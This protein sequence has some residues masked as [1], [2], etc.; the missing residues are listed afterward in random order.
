MPWC[1]QHRDPQDLLLYEIRC[2]R[3]EVGSGSDNRKEAS[4]PMSKL[5]GVFLTG[6][7][8]FDAG[9]SRAAPAA[10]PLLGVNVVGV[11]QASQKDRD[12]LIAQLQQYGVKTVRTALGGRD[13]QYT[14]F[15]ISAYQHGISAIVLTDPFAG[16]TQKHA[17]AADAAAGR[18]WGLPALSDA[19][20]EG[21][22]KVFSAQLAALEAAGVK[23][24]A[25]EFGNE[26]NTPRFNADFRPDQK[27]NRLLGVADLNNPKDVEGSTVAAGY[28]AYLK[29]LATLKALRDHSKVNS[30]TP[31]LS[32]MSAVG[33]KGYARPPGTTIPDAV[34]IAESIEF[35][36]QN[37]L[38][39]LVDGY[40][41]HAYQS[42]DPKLSA[43][44]RAALL[45]QTGVTTACTPAK[46]CWITEWGFNNPTQ[47]CPL[48][49]SMRVAPVREERDA[50]KQFISR[51]KIAAVV[52]YSW[53]GV[54][55][56]S[57]VHDTNRKE[58]PGAVYRCGALTDAGK[59]ALSAF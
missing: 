20:S 39:N 54:L 37:G 31:I 34:G 19:D 16:N 26:L 42:G 14:A 18:P 41:V 27:S 7:F 43:S 35:M 12:A 2:G 4:V 28:R 36:R 32:G 45:E 40:A 55:P 29:V 10:A 49:D 13:N 52:Y 44:A 6:L 51:G 11:D 38:D 48:D 15:V 5:Y 17:L 46:P 33:F 23:I 3:M 24:T 22:T 59:L 21:F 25:F 57:W 9:M 50:F 1:Q 8:L 30:Q 58:D 47:S 53:S 56:F